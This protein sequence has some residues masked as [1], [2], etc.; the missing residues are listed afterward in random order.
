MA[1]LSIFILFYN[2]KRAPLKADYYKAAYF[3][4]PI[5]IYLILYVIH[6][7][8]GAAFPLKDIGYNTFFNLEV[9]FHA[10]RST[11]YAI[12]NF[13]A[14][15]FFPLAFKTQFYDTI[16]FSL[17]RMKF[18]ALNITLGVASISMILNIFS[19]RKIK[20]NAL[21]ILFTS[22]LIIIYLYIV[23]IGRVVT[24]PVTYVGSVSRFAYIFNVFFFILLYSAIDFK[25]VGTSLRIGGVILVLILTALHSNHI[26][27]NIR[28]VS[29]LLSP[30][31]PYFEQ[32]R[33]F[34]ENKREEKDFSFAVVSPPPAITF[35]NWWGEGYK[36]CIE[37]HFYRYLNYR[38]PKYILKYDYKKE[39]F[40]I[41]TTSP[42]YLL[43]GAKR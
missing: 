21:V 37:G 28:Q 26:V 3:L 39:T 36:H 34:V 19:L 30:L 7:C 29:Y 9:L 32:V 6:R 41:Y 12:V 31:K 40:T 15:I 14:L 24:S 18:D 13:I 25:K 16:W 10:L 35:A 11:C 8:Y 22:C 1:S 33:T 42:P 38:N 43:E 20:E 4:M 5:L 23:S 27:K 17:D 2:K